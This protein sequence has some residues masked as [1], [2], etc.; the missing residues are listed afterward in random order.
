[1]NKYDEKIS[2]LNKHLEEHPHDY[3]GVI[4]RLK[5]QSNS[6]DY[7]KRQREI[8]KKREVAKYRKEYK[9]EKHS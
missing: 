8:K 4:S 3:M 9:D 1:M 7:E 6:I 5:N 2:R